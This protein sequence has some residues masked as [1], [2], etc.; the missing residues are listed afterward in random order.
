MKQTIPAALLAAL[1]LG[2]SVQAPAAM[3]VIEQAYE[4][5]PGQL[6]LPLTAQGRLMLHLC[7]GCRSESL[8]VDEN[9][10]YRV[11]PGAGAI[12]LD[13][14]RSEAARLAHRPRLSFFVYF[15]PQ[16]G[17]VHRLVL[18]ASQ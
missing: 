12:S 15:D 3:Q 1:L 7:D 6:V 16:S 8:R 10:E 4:L 11:I 18:D 17:L 2:A 14:L 13:E 9:T 5:D